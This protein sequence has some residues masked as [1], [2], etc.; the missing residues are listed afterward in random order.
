VQLK[1]ETTEALGEHQRVSWLEFWPDD[2]HETQ[3]KFETLQHG[4]VVQLVAVAVMLLAAT[5]AAQQLLL[6]HLA[7]TS[8]VEA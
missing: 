6:F 3:M 7:E 4:L 1:I 2:L 5:G 8:W